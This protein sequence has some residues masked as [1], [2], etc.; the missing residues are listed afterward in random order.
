MSKS[1]G[2]LR[3]RF[4][5]VRELCVV[6]LDLLLVIGSAVALYFLSTQSEAGYF[7]RVSGGIAGYVE[8]QF[9]LLSICILISMILFKTYASLWRYAMSREYLALFEAGM[10][11]Y[12]LYLLVSVALYQ[13]A[14]PA[15]PMLF[16]TMVP[17]LLMLLVRLSYRQYRDWRIKNRVSQNTTAAIIV[18]A[19]DAGVILLNEMNRNVNN[20]YRPV[21]MVDDD[22]LKIG[23][24][25]QGVPIDGPI[26]KLPE[27][28]KRYGARALYV[29]IPSVNEKRRQ[30]IL[31]IC[32]PLNCR[33]RLLPD[34]LAFSPNAEKP[35]LN[36]AREVRIE[37]LLGRPP[38]A[39]K[40][41]KS[42]AFL[43]DKVVMVTGGGGSIGS[44]LCRQ[45]ARQ[46]PER[47]II[48]D[49]YENNAYDIQQEL[50]YT[51]GKKLDLRVEI[52]S[53]RD[54]HKINRLFE[55]YHPQI[56]FHAAAH[57]HVP[58][59][60]GC[61][62]E[63]IRNNVFGTY[64]VAKAADKYQAEKF[65]LISTDKAV[66]PTNVM[67]ASKR[68]C[69]MIVQGMSSK[70]KT[71]FAAVRFGNVLGSN[72]SVIPLF[73]RQI[74]HGGP[75]TVTDKRI[76]R[77]FMTIPEA[78]GLVLQCGAMAQQ[79]EVFVLDMGD[80]VSILELAENMIRLSG[81]TP[82]VDIQ[83]EETGLR[84]GE[85]L[86]EELL[87][88]S[89]DLTVTENHKI[90]VEHQKEPVTA[91]EL[92]DKVRAL[93]AVLTTDSKDKIV[94]VMKQLVP[95]Y[96]SPEEINSKAIADLDYAAAVAK[97]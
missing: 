72:G 91:A 45:I 8:G 93:D 5:R 31:Q 14:P 85:K 65:I 34:M 6:L 78:A 39:I 57:K 73:Q 83:I 18:G 50:Q 77:Y 88:R 66:N 52:A 55:R 87:M 16:T 32:V 41:E 7:V 19:G 59:M 40:D 60:E 71:C 70:S 20:T 67:G 51:Y 25:I 28:V 27:I 68:L 95:T 10:T 44:E 49:I 42:E 1:K 75:I 69:E 4:S 80:P 2:S 94:A 74:A 24:R 23:K 3:M 53:V 30:E 36:S 76:I 61:P 90:F 92:K 21:C 64:H 58:L 86:Y 48:V 82:Y 35:L 81:Y 17:I 33:V 38:V 96:K 29:A 54:E 97:D 13:T 12:V 46:K 56:V 62:E 89:E 37:D 26:E 63:A 22:P 43:R 15:I 9:I 79:S 84:P 11:G 47:L